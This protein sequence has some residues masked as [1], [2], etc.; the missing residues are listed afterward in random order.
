VDEA[1]TVHRLDRRL[2]GLAV[3]SDPLGE[4]PEGIGIRMDGEE[5]D[6]LTGLVEDVHI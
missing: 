3:R 4:C 2:H 1:G 6:R 5:F